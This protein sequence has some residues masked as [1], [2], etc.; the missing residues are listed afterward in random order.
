MIFIPDLRNLLFILTLHFGHSSFRLVLCV[1]HILILN[2]FLQFQQLFH[3]VKSYLLSLFLYIHQLLLIFNP[4]ILLQ[5]FHFEN[6]LLYINPPLLILNFLSYFN[7]H[8]RIPKLLT[9]SSF[10]LCFISD[11][12]KVFINEIT[13]VF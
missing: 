10:S 12:G 11:F 13:D 5:D 2:R 3:I 8:Q 7:I 9:V 1:S 4:L 6:L